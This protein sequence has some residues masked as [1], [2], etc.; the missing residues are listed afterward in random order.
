MR[1]SRARAVGADGPSPGS[2]FGRDINVFGLR[3]DGSVT[4]SSVVETST[5]TLAAGSE[6][7]PLGGPPGRI[8]FGGVVGAS[9]RSASPMPGFHTTEAAIRPGIALDL[10]AREARHGA[11]GDAEIGRVL[12]D[13]DA[14]VADG[15]RGRERRAAARERIEQQPLAER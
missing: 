4:E 10:H 15:E 13:S 1:S 7:V 6:R 9:S 2:G 12:L 5:S 8:A 14:R 3:A 11:A